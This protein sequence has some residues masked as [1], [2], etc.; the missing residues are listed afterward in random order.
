MTGRGAAEQADEY[1]TALPA[2]DVAA[3]R[4][5]GVV[6][7]GV[8]VAASAVLALHVL[9]AGVLDPVAL[10]VS[11]Y[12]SVSGGRAV[13]GLAAAGL[14]AAGAAL[15]RAALTRAALTRTPARAAPR[16][17]WPRAVPVLL[18]A[19][20]LA[21]L[22]VALFPTHAPDAPADAAAV[23]HRWAGAFVFA[24]PPVAG[25]L[26]ASGT[27]GPLRSWSIAAG[28]AALVFLLAHAP[29]VLAGAPPFPLL[30]ALERLAYLVML[31]Q[32]LVSGRAAAPP[33]TRRPAAGA[34]SAATR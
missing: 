21:L 20:C 6:T 27:P 32:T 18:G 2:V 4:T 1:T 22:L 26:A 5:A 33:S 3:P 34:P 9:G 31:G 30:G 25:L 10:T 23:V 19:W 13:L 16:V 17:G 29:A 14:V 12:V 24:L 11:D 8:A 28:V 15:T 7:A